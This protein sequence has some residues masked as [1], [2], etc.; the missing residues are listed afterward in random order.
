MKTAFKTTKVVPDYSQLQVTNEKFKC[1]KCK[2]DFVGRVTVEMK[3]PLIKCNFC[4]HIMIYNP[5]FS[6]KK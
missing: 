4:E 1:R 5:A 2:S 6:R 3:N